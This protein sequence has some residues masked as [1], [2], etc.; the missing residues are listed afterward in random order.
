MSERR[1][2]DIERLHQLTVVARW[3]FVLLLWSSIGVWSLW[4]LRED[5][6]LWLDYFTWVAVFYSFTYNR[7]AAIGLGVCVGMTLGV[8]VWQSRNI[9]RGLPAEER[10]RL[11]RLAREIRDRGPKH[12][13]WRFLESDRRARK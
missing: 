1:D 13:L 2:R 5:I 12:P 8:M 3:L 6:A 9:L 4:S 7:L 10:S 11:E